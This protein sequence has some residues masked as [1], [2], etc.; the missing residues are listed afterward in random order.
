MNF[1]RINIQYNF[2]HRFVKPYFGQFIIEK[3]RLKFRG[4]FDETN[5]KNF[6]K[7][8]NDEIKSRLSLVQPVGP[9]AG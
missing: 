2:A 1:S 7:K 5:K 4:Q 3:P 6:Y 8:I 9:G